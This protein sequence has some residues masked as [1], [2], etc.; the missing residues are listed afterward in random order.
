MAAHQ[1]SWQDGRRD[2]DGSPLRRQSDE[3]LQD[4]H[5]KLM[6]EEAIA[7][8]HKRPRLL[9][10]QGGTTQRDTSLK[11]HPLRMVDRRN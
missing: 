3:L 9:P 1:V 4:Q 2:S 6:P 7:L 5:I 11:D 8:L 10:R